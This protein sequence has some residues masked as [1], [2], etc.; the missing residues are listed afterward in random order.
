[1]SEKTKIIHIPLK[2]AKLIFQITKKV[3]IEQAATINFDRIADLQRLEED[4][5]FTTNDF[6]TGIGIKLEPQLN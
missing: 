6:E 5:H 1:M 3:D 2:I 4:F